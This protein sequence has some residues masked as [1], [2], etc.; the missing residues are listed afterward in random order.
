MRLADSLKLFARERAKSKLSIKEIAS[1]LPAISRF[2]TITKNSKT[3]NIFVY[4][5]Q[6]ESGQ[7]EGVW[8]FIVSFFTFRVMEIVAHCNRSPEQQ[9]FSLRLNQQRGSSWIINLPSSRHAAHTAYSR[10]ST[11]QKTNKKRPDPFGSSTNKQRPDPFGLAPG[12]SVTYLSGSYLNRLKLRVPSVA[13]SPS[14]ATDRG[15]AS[16]QDLYL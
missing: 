9:L 12:Q 1:G 4:I 13:Q 6:C 7:T 14:I 2:I 16:G 10:R 11:Q 15:H 5:N 3:R 8:P